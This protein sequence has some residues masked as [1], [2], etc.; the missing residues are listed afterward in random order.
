MTIDSF[1]RVFSSK[2]SVTDV[3]M[4]YSSATPTSLLTHLDA[5]QRIDTSVSLECFK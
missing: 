2:S 5:F 4:N 1:R 3:W